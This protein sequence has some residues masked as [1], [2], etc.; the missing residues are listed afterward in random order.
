MDDVAAELAASLRAAAA[1]GL[2]AWRAV[3]DPGLGF[4]KTAA[5][6]FEL[7]RRLPQLRARLAAAGAPPSAPL[8]LGPSRKKFL[9][10]T[11]GERAPVL[12]CQPAAAERSVQCGA[13][14]A[15]ALRP[16]APCPRGVS[17]GEGL[18]D[19]RGGGC[20]RGG[21]RGH[22]EGAQ[23]SGRG[24]GDPRGA[25]GVAG[26][27]L[28]WGVCLFWSCMVLSLHRLPRLENVDQPRKYRYIVVVVLE[29]EMAER[30]DRIEQLKTKGNAAYVSGAAV[31]V[32]PFLIISS[33]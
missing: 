30:A 14:M 26:R 5:A 23:R 18:G 8:L 1:A 32:L 19:V 24:G 28:T 15:G 25:R 22:R 21:R 4:S 9:G 2:P 16:D 31:C 20:L 27:A 10:A 7:L 3:L 29:H 11:S 13:G 33:C 6:N 17:G 12:F